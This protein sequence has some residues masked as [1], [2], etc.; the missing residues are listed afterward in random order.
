ML[1]V[2]ASDFIFRYGGE[3][4]LAVLGNTDGKGAYIVAEKIRRKCEEHIFQLPANK[5]ISKTCSIGAAVYDGH[6]D[7]NRIVKFADMALYEAKEKGRNQV[8]VKNEIIAA[9]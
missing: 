4:F 1:N 3:E 6:P 7:Y 9:P 5:Q 2:R 8:I